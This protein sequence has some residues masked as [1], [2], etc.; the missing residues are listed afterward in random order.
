MDTC[1]LHWSG[2]SDRR[3]LTVCLLLPCSAPR[4]LKYNV[5]KLN[6]NQVLGLQSTAQ[7]VQLSNHEVPEIIPT[8]QRKQPV[9][10]GLGIEQNT[11][12]PMQRHN[13]WQNL[14]VQLPDRPCR[15]T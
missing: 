5:G 7:P 1:A 9:S 4:L 15:F 14:R 13:A 11:A 12:V 6:A 3:L 10:A 2:H 8:M